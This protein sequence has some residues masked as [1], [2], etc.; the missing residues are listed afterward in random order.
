METQTEQVFN[1]RDYGFDD[2]Y[3]KRSNGSANR[4]QN[5]K[6]W[7]YSKSDSKTLC[8]KFP[9][10]IGKQIT[11]LLGERVDFCPDKQGRILIWRGQSRK[12]SHNLHDGGKWSISMDMAYDEYIT[13]MGKFSR[14]GDFIMFSL[15]SPVQ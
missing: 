5:Q 14:L 7:M 10:S 15:I 9:P 1:P 4:S 3:C 13:Y 11:Q 12:V 2:R 6:S 8:L